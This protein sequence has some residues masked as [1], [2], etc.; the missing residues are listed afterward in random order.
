MV[1]LLSL[2]V[3]GANAV[4]PETVAQIGST[5]YAT[6]AAAVEAVPTD[7]TETTIT[8]L[9]DTTL[10]D[11][12]HISGGRNVIL[13]MNGKNVSRTSVPFIVENGTFNVIGT[14]TI[15]ETQNDQYAAIMIFGSS[16]DD[17]ENYST[18]TVGKDVILAGW[19]GLFINR[20]NSATNSWNVGDTTNK[21]CG[22]VVDFDGK[23][24]SP[25]DSSHT[26]AGNAIYVNG[27]IQDTANCPQI[28]IG[29]DAVVNADNNSTLTDSAAIYAAGYAKWTINGGTFT[30]KECVEIKAGEMTINGG[31]FAATASTTSHIASSN[32]TSTSGYAL[33]VVDN[34]SYAN[35]RS[36]TINGGN[37]AGP[38]A[39]VDDDS[40][41]DNNIASISISSGYFTTDPSDFVADGYY[42]IQSND[43]NY[44][45][46]VSTLQ[47]VAQIGSTYYATLAEAVNAVP[48]GGTATTIT[49]LNN[50]TLPSTLIVSDGR[51]IT[52]NMNGHTISKDYSVIMVEYGS[53]NVTGTGTI[54][55]TVEDGYGA[56]NI[57]GSQNVGD[58]NYTTVTVGPNVTLRAWA[59]L[60]ITPYAAGTPHA[61]GVTV[62]FNGTIYTPAQDN[63]TVAGHGIYINGQIQD[64]TNYPV[65]NIGSTAKINARLGGG[66]YAAGYAEWTIAD[67]ASI[68]GEEYGIGIKAGKL[69]INGGTIRCTGENTA[70]TEGYSNGINGSGAAIQIESNNDYAGN[71]DI[72]ITGGTITSDNGYSVY[73]YLDS[74]SSDTKVTDFDISGGYFDGGMMISSQL[75]AAITAGCPSIIGGYFTTDPSV[76]VADGYV[77]TTTT[78]SGYNYEVVAKENSDVEVAATSVPVTGPENP[79]Q[80]ETAAVDALN[81]DTTT[82]TGLE[83]AAG[84]VAQDTE[85]TAAEG[86]TALESGGVTVGDPAAV[87][88]Y[89]QPYLD[90]KVADADTNTITLNITPKV[91]TVA[92]TATSASEIVTGDSGK[93]AVEIGT[94]QVL[95]VTTPVTITIAIPESMVSS[96]PDSSF[97]PLTI[98]HVKENG[99]VY[100]Y[101]A[102]VTMADN[103]YYATF[104]VTHGFSDFTLM[105][106][107]TRVATVNYYTTGSAVS[108]K[109]YSITDVGTALPTSTKADYAF[110]GWTFTGLTGTY[111]KLPD[112]WVATTGTESFAKTATASFTYNGGSGSVGSGSISSYALTFNT[113]GGS[114][115]AAVT[116]TSGETVDLTSYVP[117][118]DSYTFAGWY[119]DSALTTQVT[120]IKLTANT[121]VYAKWAA[122]LFADV[123]ADAYYYNAVLW[124][125]DKGITQG[126]TATTF[127]PGAP[128][129]R[130]QV[131]TF[132]WRAM[133]SPTLTTTVNPFTDVSADTYYYNA[134]LWAVE[135]GITTGTTET[136][137]SPDA[138]V[139]RSQVVTFLWRA[140][141][142]PTATDASTFTDVDAGAYY[143][144]AIAWAVEKAITNGTSETTFSPMANCT[145]GQIITFLYNFEK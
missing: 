90:I 117:T 7:G 50:V 5:Y 120:S 51:D 82:A 110:N 145:R 108:Q 103:K 98:K 12:I 123:N 91:K 87:T 124:A 8:L 115:I 14:G 40:N 26:A 75:A 134:V 70:P 79:T 21:A 106:E 109:T 33:S 107:E 17:A 111:T 127:A 72:N 77:A 135:K 137:F 116:K 56:I 42:A 29:S 83:G 88:I 37:F 112:L 104:T 1:M 125:V 9:T 18:V 102:A 30:G 57:K 122:N 119:S 16:S 143:A 139:T 136:T 128:C 78:V 4:E 22:V 94:A 25:A 99:T 144:N 95:T 71:I 97:K 133:G 49:L 59:G 142:S 45:Y 89:V 141:G 44:P 13:D 60:F 62:N 31:T 55:E 32:G 6:L 81:G 68:T 73:E 132:L 61:Y 100:Y 23:I 41:A 69:N 34:A 46:M 96:F 19:S 76:Y 35:P 92:S 48:T 3:V 52:L 11:M 114:A 113:N 86:Q 43:A 140:A 66:V 126:A 93:N 15:Q 138:T 67:G 118:R 105:A 27:L 58:T 2:C 47:G 121:T 36:V 131:V 129:T 84:E 39:I 54:Q 38:V 130:A 20:T 101:E 74:G 80:E 28:T 24:L 65:I 85:T 10:T 64:T 63:H 53:L